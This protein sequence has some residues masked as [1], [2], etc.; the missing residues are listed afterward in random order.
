MLE[1]IEYAEMLEI[2]VSTVNVV[3]KQRRRKKAE[4][5]L[6]ETLIA[7]VNDR[8]RDTTSDNADDVF[9]ADPTPVSDETKPQEGEEGALHF[10][11]VPDRI[12]TVR[13]YSA[14]DGNTLHGYEQRL[15]EGGMY[16][17]NDTTSKSIRIALGVELGAICALCCGIFL[18]NVFLPNSAINT[19]F[20]AVNTPSQTEVVRPY[21]DFALRSVVSEFSDAELTLS[22]SGILSFTDECAVY[23]VADGTVSQI[24]QDA[25]GKYTVKIDHTS[26]FSGVFTGLDSVYY[27][28]GDSVKANVPMGYSEGESEVQVTMYAEGNL[29]NCFQLTEE[30]CLAWITSEE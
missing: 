18:T 23:P 8:L 24:T 21:T 15:N 30:N 7:N 9:R 25:D 11:A 19:F 17:T 22:P 2:P 3:K 5:D 13:L 4:E 26:E 20:R 28:V 29:L 16:A 6:K 27:V 14:E 1:E 12:D 10:D